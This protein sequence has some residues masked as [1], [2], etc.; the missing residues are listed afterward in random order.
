MPIRGKK[1]IW[2]QGEI[3][4]TS[5][6]HYV[7]VISKLKGH[8]SDELILFRGQPCDK[9]LLPK[10][11]RDEIKKTISDLKKFE[12][13]IF[14]DFKKRYQAYS[15]KDFSNEWDLLALAQ[16]HK[17]PTRLLDWTASALVA[18]WFAVEKE[19][20]GDCGIVWF[21]QPEEEHIITN[22][23]KSEDIF[24]RRAT[25]IFS[26]NHI[27]ER[28]TAQQGWFTCHVITSENNI[29]AVEN[30]RKYSKKLKR[31]IIHNKLFP[32]MRLMLE[33]MG[34]N[35]S[36]VYPDLTGLSQYLQWK[37]L[38]KDEYSLDEI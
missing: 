10:I 23:E 24:T 8:F 7:Q 34:I 38:K 31:L 9:P 36:T 3:V 19:I 30:N 16:H 15:R 4:I 25:K 17:L 21:F 26:P 22:Q 1:A 28:I 14:E 27:S 32:E 5:F 37:Y 18:L 35:A 33:T 13:G 20:D 29:I 6:D 11:G 2:A 12:N